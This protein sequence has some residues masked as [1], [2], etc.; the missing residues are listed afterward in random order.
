MVW[1]LFKKRSDTQLDPEVIKNSFSNIKQDMNH[2][3]SWINHFKEQHEEQDKKNE[4]HENKHNLHENNYEM[5]LERIEKLEQVL[6]LERGVEL[7][8]EQ[9][10]KD[11]P[12]ADLPKTTHLENMSLAEQ[13]ICRVLSALQ[14][15]NAGG[16]VSLKKLA[17]DSY[18]RKDYK[19]S[20]SY[21]SQVVSKLELD[22]FITKKRMGKFVYVHL[23]KE[24][25]Q[26]LIGKTNTNKKEKN[27][28]S[29]TQ[30]DS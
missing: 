17:E 15:E 6:N 8:E 12:S 22:G 27:K 2:I 3:S 30:K 9:E 14:N 20:R 18:S 23:N 13:R 26:L 16:W 25:K 11:I 29:K 5:L 19:E 7:E 10:I 4:Q 24:I 28:K 21:V 1:W